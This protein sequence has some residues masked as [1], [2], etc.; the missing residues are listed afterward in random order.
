V[1][2]GLPVLRILA[3]AELAVVARLHLRHLDSAQRRRLVELLRRGRRLS[4]AERAE[5][6]ALVAALNA[7]AFAGSAVQRLSPIPLPKRLTRARY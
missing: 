5:R 1:L 7:R 4:A 2:R 3:V 6:R